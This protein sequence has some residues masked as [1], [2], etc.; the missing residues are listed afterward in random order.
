MKS[1]RAKIM[2]LLFYNVLIS[3]LIIGA[4]GVILTTN[5]IKDKSTENMHLL[6]KNKA[7]SVDITFAK[8]EE[9]VNTLAHYAESELSNIEKIKDA[10][11]RKKYSADIQK[12]ALHHIERV[13]GAAAIYLHYDYEYIGET[14]GFY[15]VK[16]NETDQF[17][18][19]PL[20]EI[21]AESPNDE[22]VGWWY[23]P[24]ISGEKTW[25]EAYYDANLDRYVVSYVVPIYKNEQLIGVIGADI[26]TDYIEKLV[27]EVSLFNSGQAAVLKSDGTVL[28]HPNF[29]RGVLI[30]EGD[31]GFEGVIE[32][33]T[34]EDSTKEL[35]SYKLKGQKKKLA[36]CK[37]RNGMLMVCFAPET[38][39]Y[40]NSNMLLLANTILIAIVVLVALFV[41]F[42]V[43]VR[44]TRPIKKLSEAAK[45][46]TVGEFDFDIE[47]ETKDEIAEL[48]RTFIE[49]RKILKHQIHLLDK[50]AHRDGLTGV[51]NKSAFMDK[52]NEINKA[53][54][55]GNADFSVVVL[56][57]NKLKVANDVFG[58][59]AGDRL[60]F[61]VAE[62]LSLTFDDSNVYRLGGDEFAVI[63]SEEEGVDNTEKIISCV[64]AMHG[65]TVEGFPDCKAT[66]AYGFSRFDRIR[67]HQLSDVLRRADKEMYKNKAETKKQTYPWQAGAKGIKQ[68]Q[69]DK[70]HELL[71]SLKDSTD[72][73]LF[74]MNIETGFIHFYGK[75]DSAFHIADGAEISD[76]INEL[77]TFIH[78][79]DH[80]LIKEA[81]TSI[82]NHDAEIIDVNFRMH[83]ND[84]NMRWVSCRGNIIKDETDSHFLLIGRI[85]LNAVKHLYNPITTLFNKNKF[86]AD[87]QKD[88][89]N[90]FGNLMLIDIDNLSEIN[91]KHGSAYGD[92]LLKEIAENLESKFSMQQIYHA[93][94]D[95][96]VI[97]L[98]DVSTEQVK[99]I[100]NWLK[101]AMLNKCSIS[102]SVVPNDS[103][104]HINSDNIYSYAVQILSNAKK[105]GVGQLVF[106]SKE[107]M[108]ERISAAE[109]LEELEQSV[110]NNCD[111]FYLVY[112]PQIN[113][114]DYSIVSAEALLRFNSETKGQVYPD[115][116]IPVL[117]QT[118]LIN[119]VGIWVADEAIK[120]CKEWRKFKDNFKISVNIS[121][122]QLER[123]D[124]AL[125][126][127]NLLSKYELP[128]D[129][130][131]LEFTESIQFNGNE[132]T[133]DIINTLR[134]SGIQIAID[135]FGT[136]YS[137]LGNLKNIQAN[138]LKIDRA[139]IKDIKENGYNYNLIC[140]ILEFAKSNALNVCLEGVETKDELVVLSGLRP[141]IFQ[142]YLFDRPCVP[143]VLE[144][145]YFNTDSTEYRE[146]LDI[147][148]QLHKEKRHA[149]I[150][151]IEMKAILSGLDIG[152]WIMRIDSESGEGEL[153]TDKV[154]KKLLGVNDDI[155]PKE[156]Y[157]HWR[158][159][160]SED[161][162]Q[163]INRSIDEMQIKGDAIARVEYMW[164]HP[165]K[166]EIFVRSSAR[167]SDKNGE[168]TV[169]EGFHRI[170]DN[171]EKSC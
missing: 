101:E 171:T 78:P 134:K 91:L 121:P 16:N 142:G 130:L 146:R 92:T 120:K 20:H 31:P 69:I 38:E 57:V 157:Q 89:I 113:A 100:F 40:H 162:L 112:Q 47:I 44:L 83:N 110:N 158:K 63:I 151:N 125:R 132:D 51:G 137:N 136:G 117:E 70:Y 36:S 32:K 19:H 2:W 93:E 18:Y 80:T 165:E 143:D 115:R 144:S 95:R 42:L 77:L 6:C 88:F 99:E 68:L 39:I 168:F 82:I 8:I 27:K 131:I 167:C 145:K 66:C 7:D 103:S 154:M 159:N 33:L 129:A 106:F 119:E 98:N 135:D 108:L 43:S 150:V 41:A 156:C 148:K 67:D 58:H 138:I 114:E 163:H 49:T 104:M 75:D 21:S 45:N 13:V 64:E 79:N 23:V 94:K 54:A 76:K 4:T 109:L 61:T 11:F 126:I 128:G 30:G 111:G 84:N 169:F 90:K 46:L 161:Y 35:I 160:I 25:F 85:S 60:L 141:Q 53:I 116:F 29:E 102:A 48:S 26:F 22:N 62:H 65:L 152:L 139:F 96:F 118:R 140:N 74:L 86:K 127:I 164:N 14:D 12:N 72:D 166:G 55:E 124:F 105:D 5:V 10:S 3:S 122:K 52:E 107:A 133:F 170:I 153:Y 28:Y 15:Y 17:K 81:I 71:Q 59:I 155:T 37:L 123:K 87:L 34:L 97:L 9:S 24:T 50:E 149:P 1:I 147:M 73:Y 56:D